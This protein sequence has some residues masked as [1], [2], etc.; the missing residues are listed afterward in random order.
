MASNTARLPNTVSEDQILNILKLYRDPRALMP[1]RIA[2][3]ILMVCIHTRASFMD[4]IPRQTSTTGD[5]M[6]SIRTQTSLGSSLITPLDPTSRMK[7]ETPT[8]QGYIQ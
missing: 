3:G 2:I 4:M 5:T 7:Y 1:T 8:L 6:L